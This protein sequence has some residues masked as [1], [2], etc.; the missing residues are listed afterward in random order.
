MTVDDYSLLEPIF[1]A[2]LAE[3]RFLLPAADSTD[4]EVKAYWFGGVN[5]EFWALEEN[6]EI[7]G[8]FY[9]RCNH[10]GLGN[11]VANG[12]YVIAPHAKGRGLGRTLGEYSLQRARERGFHG[13]QFNFV[14]ANNTV[15]LTL[16]K[17]L[18]FSV[19]GTIPNGYHYQRTRYEDAYIMYKDLTA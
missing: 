13:M 17:S 16:W 6:G 12:G 8:G 18:G 4:D 1:R 14:V 5:N 2:A 15:A 10:G 7:L 11:H 19:I 9:Q 3:E